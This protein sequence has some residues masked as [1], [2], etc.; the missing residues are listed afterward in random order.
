[1]WKTRT[2]RKYSKAL[3]GPEDISLR[4]ILRTVLA[5]SAAAFAIGAVLWLWPMAYENSASDT[6][7][8]P[9]L[10]W[11]ALVPKDWNPT[12]RFDGSSL[13]N[14]DDSDPKAIELAR[15]M[16]EA[17]DNAPTKRSLDGTKATLAGY[18]V[19]LQSDNGELKEFLLVPFFGACIHVPP[20]P[21]NQIVHVSLKTAVKD[22]RTMSSV[23]VAGIL[24][25]QRQDSA[26]GV[27]GYVMDAVS[28]QRKG[29]EE[30]KS[31][32]DFSRR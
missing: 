10:G 11:E 31:L 4:T 32:F 6:S 8:Y 9:S 25:T 27:S 14:T 19:P 12:S 15:Q 28:I 20:P 16:R 23:R 2:T 18:V 30:G 24:R 1:M 5:G 3:N 22:I 21:S 17:W 7:G 26:M 29:M 13:G